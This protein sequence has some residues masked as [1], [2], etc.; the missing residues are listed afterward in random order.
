MIVRNV[1]PL[2]TYF[3]KMLLANYKTGIGQEDYLSDQYGDPEMIF[4]K[5]GSLSI[6]P[7]TLINCSS[8]RVLF[9]PIE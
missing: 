8:F 5:L 2:S 7:D 9:K 6:F 4:F 1:S 3:F